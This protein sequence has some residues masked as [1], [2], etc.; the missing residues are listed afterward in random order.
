MTTPL[1]MH[2]SEDGKE[3]VLRRWLNKPHMHTIAAVHCSIGDWD[4]SVTIQDC[5][6]SITLSIDADNPADLINSL[7]KIDSLVETLLITRE[8][9]IKRTLPAR[10][11]SLESS[12][13]NANE[14]EE[15]VKE[16]KEHIHNFKKLMAEEFEWK[17]PK[18]ELP[19][20]F[21]P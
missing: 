7:G 16:R 2:L 18:I 21:N 15:W 13:K 5:T 17:P 14:K 11:R 3:L 12:I 9:L 20:G 4:A 1:E 6:R 8:A 10:V 19:S